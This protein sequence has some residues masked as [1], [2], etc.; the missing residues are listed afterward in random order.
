MELVGPR[1][2]GGVD[3]AGRRPAVLG[4]ETGRLELR[5]GQSGAG[6]EQAH[7]A[8]AAVHRGVHALD[9]DADLGRDAAVHRRQVVR[10]IPIDDGRQLPHGRVVGART[11]GDVLRYLFGNRRRQRRLVPADQR[12]LAGD[13]DRLLGPGHE[14]QVDAPPLARI[15]VGRQFGRAQPFEFGVH[16]VAPGQQQREAVDAVGVGDDRSRVLRAGQGDGDAG[17]R[18]TLGVQDPAVDRAGLRTVREQRNHANEDDKPSEPNRTSIHASSSK[19]RVRPG[20]R[21]HSG[22]AG[23][24]PCAQDVR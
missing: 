16:R 18:C 7:L 11:E 10:V 19:S 5:L 21:G 6:D 22:T 9:V 17:Q 23:T 15:E 13:R 14:G 24:I 8:A 3:D 1:L 12:R 4:A 2:D 20:R